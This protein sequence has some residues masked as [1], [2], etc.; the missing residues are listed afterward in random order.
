MRYCFVFVFV[1][2]LDANLVMV[3]QTGTL[4]YLVFVFVFVFVLVF[5]FGCQPG[6]GG[7]DWDVSLP[8]NGVD[9]NLLLHV[10]RHLC[11]GLS[12]GWFIF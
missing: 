8:W 2:D 4:V 11:Q 1:F 10:G 9:I 7:A 3:V 5:V 6:H 12:G